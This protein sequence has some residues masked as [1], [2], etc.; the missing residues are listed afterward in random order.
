M[1]RVPGTI[2]DGTSIAPQVLL[3]IVSR[4]RNKYW[5]YFWDM[6]AHSLRSTLDGRHLEMTGALRPGATGAAN[7]RISISDN[8]RAFILYCQSGGLWKA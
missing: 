3:S 6:T 4:T 1:N 5:R 2:V 8:R 7:R